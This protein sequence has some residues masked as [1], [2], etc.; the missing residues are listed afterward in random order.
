V[1]ARGLRL[2]DASDPDDDSLAVALRHADIELREA[3]AAELRTREWTPRTSEDRAWYFVARR[4]WSN[5]ANL[6]ADAVPALVSAIE[7]GIEGT[8]EAVRALGRTRDA[9]GF[10][11]LAKCASNQD[12]EIRRAA[13]QA[14]GALGD[15][16]AGEVLE[17]LLRDSHF[18]APPTS[19]RWTPAEAWGMPT[20]PEKSYFRDAR[21][22]YPVRKAAL[23]ALISLRY[24]GTVAALL[25]S[26]FPEGEPELA[27]SALQRLLRE[28]RS[29]LSTEDLERIADL[30]LHRTEVREVGY[31]DPEGGE[32]GREVLHV[33]VDCDDLRTAAREELERRRGE[34]KS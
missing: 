28:R 18:Q 16:R 34:S 8:P 5:A 2:S 14:L 9:R 33:E 31:R 15:G 30:R 17:P 26:P 24:S 19:K 12:P 7:S 3:A 23:D 6:G 25:A 4:S 21:S 20:T 27:A 13:A 22:G 11:L 10:D 1:L 29:E 32:S